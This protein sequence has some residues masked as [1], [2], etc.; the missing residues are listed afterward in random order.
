M[1]RNRA[2]THRPPFTNYGPTGL[3]YPSQVPESHRDFRTDHRNNA[4]ATAAADNPAGTA[5]SAAVGDTAGSEAAAAVEANKNEL[6]IKEYGG[7]AKTTVSKF[8]PRQ[9]TSRK[10]VLPAHLLQ[11]VTST[12]QNGSGGDDDVVSA[13]SSAARATKRRHVD[14]VNEKLRQ[15]AFI[16]AKVSGCAACLAAHAQTSNSTLELLILGYAFML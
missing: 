1:F 15:D 7:A 2:P 5:A 13:S 16:L 12:L 9:T 8:V 4:A 10:T 14:P 11:G 3:I 6:I